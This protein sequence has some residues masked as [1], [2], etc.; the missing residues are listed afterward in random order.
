M[1]PARRSV[2]SSRPAV[3]NRPY[4]IGLFILVLLAGCRTVPQPVARNGQEF[5]VAGQHYPAGTRIVTWLEPGGYDAYQPVLAPDGTV[6]PKNHA[7][8][9][10]HP[11]LPEPV[12]PPDFAALRKLVDQFVLHYDTM[13]L[14]GACFDILQRRGLSVHFLLDVDGTIYQTLDLQERAYHATIANSRSIGIE[15]ANLGAYPVG[16]KNP[17]AAWYQPDETGTPYLTLPE[18]VADPRIR[19]P[20]FTARPARPELVT[21]NVQGK[22]LV[23]YDFTPE[24]YAALIKLTAAL[25]RIFP[26]LK[27]DCPRD[28]AGAPLTA[29][30]PDEEWAAFGGVIGHFHLQKNKVDPGPAMQ[31]DKLI[32]GA[33]LHLK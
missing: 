7:V 8:R 31:W 3:N 26:K 5:I 25:H 13:G 6:R 14:S 27:L 20:G 17:F 11:D 19:T 30:M 22:N 21:G 12:E 9:R 18:H 15:I 2:P 33:R 16:E 24:Q 28:A 1:R 23:Q 29:K 10:T 32:E 4:L